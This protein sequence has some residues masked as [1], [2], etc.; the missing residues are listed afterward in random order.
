MT[1]RYTEN[2]NTQAAN[3]VVIILIVMILIA[4]LIISRFK[5]GSLHKGLGL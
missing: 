5:G 3:A 1:M 2:G 4:N